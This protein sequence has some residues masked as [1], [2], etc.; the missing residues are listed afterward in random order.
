ML[1]ELTSHLIICTLTSIDMTT[2]Y[3]I[4]NSIDVSTRKLSVVASWPD[5][6]HFT[7]KKL[8]KSGID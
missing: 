2:P 3:T 1:E 8:F 5:N 4:F 7:Q 6:T